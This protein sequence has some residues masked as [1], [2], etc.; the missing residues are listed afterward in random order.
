VIEQVANVCQTSC[1]QDAWG[2]GQELAVHGWIYG[3][4]DGLLRD[5]KTT[6][7]T[8]EEAEAAYRTALTALE[9]E[10]AGS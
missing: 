10:D 7:A 8:P 2:Q 3:L 6:A 4:R 1:V 9:K 5:L